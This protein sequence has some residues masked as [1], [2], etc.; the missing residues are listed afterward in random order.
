MDDIQIFQLSIPESMLT[1]AFSA[2]AGF[3]C[4]ASSRSFADNLA[5]LSFSTGPKTPAF[6]LA[7]F[8]FFVLA[9]A[10]FAILSENMLMRAKL[11]PTRTVIEILQGEAE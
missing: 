9:R 10:P 6:N 1:S 7:L 11:I 2:R 4:D 5:V 3:G 8:A